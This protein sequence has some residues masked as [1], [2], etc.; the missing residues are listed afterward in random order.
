MATV[1][2]V[3]HFVKL[4]WRYGSGKVYGFGGFRGYTEREH[5]VMLVESLGV[6]VG[7]ALRHGHVLCG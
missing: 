4:R 1:L 2:P 3:G 5:H 6:H 7:H